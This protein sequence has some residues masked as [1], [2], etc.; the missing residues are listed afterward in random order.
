[1]TARI[2]MLLKSRASLTC[3]RACFLP[4]RAY[5]HPCTSNNLES[6]WQKLFKLFTTS[7]WRYQSK[8]NIYTNFRL[9]F[10]FGFSIS[11]YTGNQFKPCFIYMNGVSL[12]Q[13][14]HVETCEFD[15]RNFVSNI[16][17]GIRNGFSYENYGY[18]FNFHYIPIHYVLVCLFDVSNIYIYIY[19][20]KHTHICKL[21]VRP[22]YVTF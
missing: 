15:V 2:S 3:F 7:W 16:L 18:F 22:H 5:Q 20:H 6:C 9:K 14:L 19:I 11:F 1:M 12:L 4:G 21:L 8:I 10:S 13:N 17:L